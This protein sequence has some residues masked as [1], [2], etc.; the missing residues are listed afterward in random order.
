LTSGS[1]LEEQQLPLIGL[2]ESG[3]ELVLDLWLWVGC[4]GAQHDPPFVIA[5]TLPLIPFVGLSGG[6]Y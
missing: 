6:S 3:I 1:D 4:F 2:S 5:S